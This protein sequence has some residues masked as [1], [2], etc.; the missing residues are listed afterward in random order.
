[1]TTAASPRAART[2][3]FAFAFVSLALL[4]STVTSTAAADSS[5]V[6]TSARHCPS[7]CRAE[8][9]GPGGF[10]RLP[11][12][13][14]CPRK[15]IAVVSLPAAPALSVRADDVERAPEPTDIAAAADPAG[16]VPRKHGKKSSCPKWCEWIPD[17]KKKWIPT[18]KDCK[19][20]KSEANNNNNDNI[21]ARDAADG[22]GFISLA[23]NRKSFLLSCF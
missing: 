10:L 7:H 6:T 20:S 4:C 2:V 13:A 19:S 14:E 8:G 9:W 16:K 22:R 3:M 11:E 5:T 23:H 18:C 17:D 1:M 15:A 12:C 21:N